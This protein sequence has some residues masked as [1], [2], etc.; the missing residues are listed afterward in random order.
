MTKLMNEKLEE[1]QIGKKEKTKLS[2]S[3]KVKVDI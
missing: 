2:P 3:E 1:Q